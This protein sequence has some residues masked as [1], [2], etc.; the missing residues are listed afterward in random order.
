MPN[1]YFQVL[2]VPRGPWL[3]ESVLRESFQRLAAVAHPDLAG[4][5]NARFAELNA[6]WQTL[7]EPAARLR[8]YLELEHPETLSALQHTPTEL[9]ELFM[10]IADKQQT[11]SRL[12]AE[13]GNATSPLARALLEP[14]RVALRKQIQALAV[15]IAEQTGA[16]HGALQGD[17]LAPAG[18]AAG[19]NQLVFLDKWA[20]QVR[21]TALALDQA[22]LSR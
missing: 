1:D 4:G 2:Q 15:Q 6:A 5:S 20:E 9:S 19:L 16:I 18:L 22:N 21:E 13:L 17:A 7:R 12:L 14:R 8:H 10:D 11:A 3:D